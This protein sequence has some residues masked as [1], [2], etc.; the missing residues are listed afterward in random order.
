RERQVYLRARSRRERLQD[1]RVLIPVEQRPDLDAPFRDVLLTSGHPHELFELI[2]GPF[3]HLPRPEAAALGHRMDDEPALLAELPVE[4][5]QVIA[6]GDLALDDHVELSLA[7]VTSWAAPDRLRLLRSPT[8]TDGTHDS[9]A[10][11]RRVAGEA[12]PPATTRGT[13][14]YRP[15]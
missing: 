4:E 7:A 14:P 5:R 13:A 6:L 15:R 2:D 10:S 11:S 9:A 1:A 3:N 8:S 12:M